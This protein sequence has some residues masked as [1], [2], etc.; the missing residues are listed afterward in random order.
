MTEH[1]V[2]AVPQRQGLRRPL[3]PLLILVV[4]SGAA[5]LIYE[6]VWFQLIE[7]VI[8]S[9]AASLAIVLGTFMGGLCA[10]SLAFPRLVRGRTHPLRVYAA[11]EAG[12]GALGVAVPFVLPW[13]SEL[14]DAAA[15][16]GSV[17]LLLR[18]FVAALC[19][20]PPT[21]LMGATFPAAARWVDSSPRG[22]SRLG[23]LYA[24]NITGAVAGALAAGFYLLPLHDLMTATWLAASLNGAVALLALALAGAWP[25]ARSPRV[26]RGG[27]LP[28][29][30]A[31]PGAPAHRAATDVDSGRS[32]RETRAALMVIALSGSAALGAEVVWTRLLALDLG[33]TVYTFS[34]IL[35]VFLAGLGLGASAGAAVARAIR[36]HLL[37]LGVCQLLLTIA[38]A[39]AARSLSTPPDPRGAGDLAAGVGWL[40]AAGDLTRALRD[41][42]PPASLWGASFPLALAA[43]AR[44][45][46][47]PARIAA[48][49]AACNTLGAIVGAA[50]FSLLVVPH[51]GTQAAQ[52]LL[53][54]LSAVGGAVALGWSARA[55]RVPAVFA[56]GA[57]VL[58]AAPSVP[59]VSARLVAYGRNRARVKDLKRVLYLG[60]GASAS[61]AVTERADGMRAF[62]VAG[63][64]EA[65]TDPQDLRLERML[66]HFP[67]LLHPGPRSVLVVGFGAGITAGTFL[68][69]PGIERIV[70]C[71]IEP[72]IPPN[73]APFFARENLDVLSDPRVDIV[74]DDA[75]HF[76][77]TTNETFD[78]ITSDPIHPWVRGS[79][80]LYTREYLQSVKRLLNPGGVVS[81]WAPLYENREDAVRSEVATFLDVFPTGTLW[82]SRPGPGGGYDLI[83]LA[84]DGDLRINPIALQYRLAQPQ[85]LGVV[86]SLV[87][88]GFG[89]PLDL[90]STFAGD[91]ATMAE[92]LRDAPLN[93]DRNLRLQYVAGLRARPFEH[94]DTYAHL[95]ARRAVPE[96]LFAAS[97]DWLAQLRAALDASPVRGMR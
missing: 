91:R 47:D 61:V 14:Y 18:G 92:W 26:A 27:G 4:A 72:L 75:R 58:A 57:L 13:I 94:E 88:S 41:I 73:V 16:S 70:I 8:G 2:A 11:L 49:V 22:M 66:A 93:L 86:R 25:M 68:L 28:A 65:S 82:G 56:A 6:V 76:V 3:S 90:F 89:S 40:T 38:V 85:Y 12:T 87:E 64:V 81:E 71:E 83:L 35:A 46:A 31:A 1:E 36:H 67:A 33:P 53:I 51:G 23:A 17:G 48:A 80:T 74:Y 19:L 45:K 54:G 44:R 7:L 79:A 63:K 15:A 29:P 50:G 59:P 97:A 55:M 77:R 43:A 30:D 60:E 34:I 52:Q 69:Y 20:L 96:S 62:H 95:V 10:G 9:T 21:L 84:R 37:A 5:A 24:G 78:V 32:E 42:L 39:V